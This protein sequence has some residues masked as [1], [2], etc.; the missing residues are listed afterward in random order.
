MNKNRILV[1]VLILVLAGLAVFY[2]I[3]RGQ[4]GLPVSQPGEEAV[5]ELPVT[6]PEPT[7]EE[8]PAEGVSDSF[9]ESLIDELNTENPVEDFAETNPFTKKI[10]PFEDVYKNPFE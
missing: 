7:A 4:F 1:I 3:N 10:N 8:V 6:E 9:G 2:F 5:L